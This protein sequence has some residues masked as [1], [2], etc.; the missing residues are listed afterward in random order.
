MKAIVLGRK[1]DR[2]LVEVLPD[3]ACAGCKACSRSQGGKVL[4]VH[5]EKDYDEGTLV[6]IDMEDSKLLAASF[7]AYGIPL[8]VF[9]ASL[10]LL[11]LLFS[12]TSLEAYAEVISFFGSLGVLAVTYL[13]IYY[14]DAKR[15]RE[16][17]FVAR[18]TKEI[19]VKEELCHF[20]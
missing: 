1:R 2:T 17:R 3:E 4:L 20:S 18:I 16:G 6:E 7:I 12:R 10:F 8:I 19:E 14:T 9:F 13:I 15:S 11:F 5:A